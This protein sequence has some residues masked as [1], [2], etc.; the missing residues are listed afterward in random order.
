M[1]WTGG[2]WVHLSLLKPRV[3]ETQPGAMGQIVYESLF[4]LL[5]RLFNDVPLLCVREH[6]AHLHPLPP[7]HTFTYTR[8]LVKAPPPGWP[9]PVTSLF[10]SASSTFPAHC[11]FCFT[12]QLPVVLISLLSPAPGMGGSWGREPPSQLPRSS[13]ACFI[14][15]QGWEGG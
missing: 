10:T 1:A 8:F 2:S 12:P 9:I 3:S 13:T 14:R 7:T 6:H 4:H 11:P 5:V 15:P